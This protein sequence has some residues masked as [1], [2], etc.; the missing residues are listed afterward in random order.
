MA[1]QILKPKSVAPPLSSSSSHIYRKKGHDHGLVDSFTNSLD[2]IAMAKRSFKRFV[3]QELGKLPLF[4]IYAV[5]EWV[6]I[7]VLFIDGFL[8]FFANE[9]AKFFELKIPCLLCT[10]IDHVLVHRDADFYYNESICETH[11]KEVSCLAYCHVHKK[12]SDIRNMCEGCLLSFATERDSDCDLYKSHAGVLQKDM[13]QFA[14]DDRDIHLRFPALGN[15]FAVQAEKSGLHQCSCCGE[16]LKVKSYSKGKIA[17]TLSQAPAPSP[18]APFVSLRNEGP[19]KLD[20]SHVRY[21]ELKFSENY[22]DLHDDEDG[23]NA[24][25]LDKQFREEV[26]AAMVPLLTESENMSEERTPAFS[27]GNKFFGI[28]LTDSAAASPRACTRF[29]RRSL[30]DRTELSSETIE[31]TSLSDEVDGASVLQHLKKQVRLDRKSLMDLYMELDEER[32][33]SAVAANN[34]MAMITRLQAEKAAVQMEALQYQRMMEEQEEYD[35]EAL[36]ATRDIVS[37]REEQIKTLEAE[38]VAYREKYG[39]LTG[40]DFM[41]SGGDIDDEDYND[42]NTDSHSS[43]TERYECL[44]PAYSSTE[45]QNN[46]ENVF[47][48]SQSPSFLAV[49]NG[50]LKAFQGQDP[51]RVGGLTNLDKKV[52]FSSDD[53]DLS[54]R[55]SSDDANHSGKVTDPEREENLVTESSNLH[56][57]SQ[58]L[59][60]EGGF[61]KHADRTLQNGSEVT[62]DSPQK[63]CQLITTVDHDA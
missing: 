6:L 11:K 23:S 45:G 31:G 1:T 8:A 18:R 14:G 41:E 56:G 21:T 15:D 13:E 12:L 20:L 25:H 16:P 9:F 60:E 44:S 26:K 58:A 10:R 33:A 5:L 42:L 53:G 50:S 3:E 19:R 51:H 17:G 34:A 37:K 2:Q 38:L 4:L 35:Q 46:A 62:S 32:S 57:S 43:Y 47:Y 61:L 55:S 7:A 28:P 29:P 63:I 49:E 40:E 39:V 59:D 52:H 30:H 54:S 24:S 36:Q 22:S 27:R 48:Q